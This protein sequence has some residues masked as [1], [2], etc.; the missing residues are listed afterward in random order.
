VTGR[1]HGWNF[2]YEPQPIERPIDETGVADLIVSTLRMVDP[3]IVQ[4]SVSR[5]LGVPVEAETVLSRP[6]LF[7]T[8]LRAIGEVDAQGV[9]EALTADG[10]ALR[11]VASARTPS[12]ALPPEL[13][14]A[15]AP[16]GC[17]SNW[18][19]RKRRPLPDVAPTSGDWFL[20][21]N[22]GVNVD[23]AVCG[24]GAGTRLAVIDD[25][26]A[27]I[28][29]VDLDRIVRIGVDDLP[30]T[31]GHAALM[32]GWAAGAYRSDGTRFIGVAPDASVRVYC[33]PK[34]GIEVL[35]LP[36]ALARA[37]FDGADVVVCAT[38]LGGGAVSPMLDDALEVA[39]RIGRRGRGTV[40]VLPTGREAS[41]CGTSV[42]ASL[43]L[44]LGDP[45]SD[46]RVH[47]IAPGGASGG[48]FLWRNPRGVVRPFANRGPAVRWV[49]P[50]DDVSYPLG[51]DG[52]ICHAESSGA[53]AIAAGVIL[54]VIA[55]NPTL[56]EREL[57]ALLDRTV[58]RCDEDLSATS[59]LADPAD[60]RPHGYDPDGHNARTGYGRLDASRACTAARDPVALVLDAIGE[61][62]AAVRW[63][64]RGCPPYS[65]RAARW[66]ARR[67][68]VRPDLEHA[69]RTLARHERLLAAEPSRARAHPPEAFARQLGV[70]AREFCG[71]RPPPRV[72]EELSEV[73]KALAE[74]SAG[75][76]HAALAL[77]RGARAILE[78][79]SSPPGPDGSQ[80]ANAPVSVQEARS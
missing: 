33:I 58:R 22:G 80:T 67:L 8:R 14:F 49:A 71:C 56:R 62:R 31:S 5:A 52:R 15:E 57:H 11:Y 17:P 37:V 66:M 39:R 54:L 69:A 32:V 65:R 7:W 23:R 30:A 76:A 18:S 36:L 72:L 4:R 35:S 68:L 77:D 51:A 19:V 55:A 64:T 3:A 61:R 40:V 48:W 79:P 75:A 20:G 26:I 10:I 12:T 38:Y 13:S 59:S 21:S 46:P 6:P 53:S 9:A 47:C 28:E 78:E 63:S 44:G 29:R 50:G 60:V 27:D 43:S 74:A 1:S 42:H 2:G 16:A 34:P 73:A 70:L 45:A 41:S 24:T 25:E